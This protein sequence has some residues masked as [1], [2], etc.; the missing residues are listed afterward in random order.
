[1][2]EQQDT[3]WKR[4]WKDEYLEEICAFANAQ[5]GEIY[6][7]C[8]DNGNVVG[9]YNAQ[10]LL[11]D[12]PK[13][14]Q[15]I[16]NLV[17]SVNLLQ[18]EGKDYIQIIIPPS[19][20]AV[21]CKGRFFYRSGS[22]CILLTGIALPNFLA[23]KLD[24]NWESQ[25]ASQFSLADINTAA[26]EKF[27]EMAVKKGR[28]DH[29]ILNEKTGVLLQ[30][31]GLMVNGTLT[32]AAMLLFSR[33]PENWII[34]AHIKVGYF[35][36][37]A[38]L[39]YQD[40]VRGGLLE[41][42]D[43]AVDLIYFKYMK[44]KI[45]YVGLQRQERYFVPEAALREALLNAVCH[46]RYQSYVP[47]QVSV[48]DDKLY[49]GNCGSLPETWTIDSLLS[50]HVSIPFNPSIARVF[51][52]AGYIERWGRGIEKICEACEADGV[53]YPEYRVNAMDIMVKF[54]APEDRVVRNNSQNY[55]DST[56]CT[57][58]SPGNYRENY[59]ENEIQL[60][61]MLEEDPGY[62]TDVLSQRLSLS[63]K[64]VANIIKKFKQN[65]II[66]RVG[67]DRKGYWKILK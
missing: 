63:P 28:M 10:R 38:D 26:I 58:T 33:D 41:Q 19:S 7:G 2:A 59:R 27:K 65:G 39:I 56:R 30:K 12:I 36:T 11:E 49:I 37:D 48:Y 16:L 53:P 5:G 8:D 17:L 20:L 45:T 14:I 25:P 31:L 24:Y 51:Y 46:K 13:K 40:D 29:G 54:T 6:I 32:N 23:K 1:M 4:I 18:K 57:A 50:K 44:A 66:E 47:V 21:S 42:I 35:E 55:S 43:K 52:L 67:S 64:T 61:Q 60:L 9:L 34:G 3:E 15:D 62:T 22:N